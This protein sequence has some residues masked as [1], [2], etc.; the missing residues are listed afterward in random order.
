MAN[1]S[2]GEPA[3]K[4][5]T[6]EKEDTII[7]LF[8]GQARSQEIPELEELMGFLLEK[9]QPSVIFSFRD[10]VSFLPG[11]HSSFAKIQSSL[12]KAGKLL[13]L[14]SFKPEIKNALLL[15]GVIRESEIFNNIPE[16][17]QALRVR[18]H[19]SE[20]KAP[21]GAALAAAEKKAA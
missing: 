20:A 6:G 7:V 16:C 9:P 12:R 15:A 21:E 17:W 14:C 10:V 18:L 3:F 8:L 4:V 2:N 19:E 1:N 13:A 11:A 5:V